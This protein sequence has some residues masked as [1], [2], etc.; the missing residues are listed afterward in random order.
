MGDLRIGWIVAAALGL[1]V[2]VLAASLHRQFQRD[3]TA[4]Y[5]CL[6]DGGH[7]MLG[8][9]ERI[10]SGIAAFLTKHALGAP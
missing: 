1:A 8:H 5:D 3:I 7:M 10:R 9:N 6:K 4:A 2:V